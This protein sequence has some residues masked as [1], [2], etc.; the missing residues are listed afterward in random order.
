[1]RNRIS[2]VARRF[3]D[4]GGAGAWE[5]YRLFQGVYLPTVYIGLEFV[6]DFG[7]YIK[8]IQV[9]VNDTLRHLFR[10]PFGLANNILLAEFGTP[11]V[12]V[13]ARYLQ[14]RCYARMITHRF[15][16]HFP[17]FGSI[18]DHWAAA[19][20]EADVTDLEAVPSVPVTEIVRDKDLAIARHGEQWD[21]ALD[22]DMH[23]IYTNGFSSD[24]KSGAGWV[25]YDRD[26][27]SVCY[28]P[29]SD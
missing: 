28:G 3:G 15:G 6:G 20:F 21:G 13:Q 16:G 5:T 24:G 1:M 23:V 4:V 7:Y 17:W 2:A 22:M 10:L 8:R 25:C 14:R 9:H 27:S 19:A 12:H 26:L 18:R 29:F 11:P